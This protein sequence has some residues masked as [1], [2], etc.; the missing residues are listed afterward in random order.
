V[1]SVDGVVS[2]EHEV[3]PYGPSPA[4]GRSVL[5]TDQAGDGIC[6]LMSLR[7]FTDK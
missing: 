5:I 4:T 7:K 3:R 2:G 1:K 6:G